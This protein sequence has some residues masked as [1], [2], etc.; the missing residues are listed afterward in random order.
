MAKSPAELYEEREKRIRDA[1]A[2]KE[3]DRVPFLFGLYNFV[4][5]Y[6][7]VPTSAAYYDHKAWKEA[8][9]KTIVDFEPDLY[10]SALGTNAGVGL[11]VLG[12]KVYKW[13]GFNLEANSSPQFVEDEYM[14]ED[15]YDQFLSD[16]GDFPF[17][18]YLPRAYSTLEPLAKLPPLRTLQS[19]AIS[20]ASAIFA[21]PE[22]RKLFDALI[23]AGEEEE[24]RRKAFG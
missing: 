6:T 5:K 9:K 24:K 8:M 7:G 11:E 22:F 3:P 21:T 10:R 20:N 12:T 19:L 13:A 14:K 1:A 23:K 2:L 17:R 18:K 4:A 16:P 15:E